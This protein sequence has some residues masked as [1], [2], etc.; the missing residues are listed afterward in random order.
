MRE[1]PQTARLRLPQ[2][3]NAVSLFSWC[4]YFRRSITGHATSFIA[5][6]LF[7]Q[8][9]LRR[10]WI[11]GAVIGVLG[12]TGDGS[13][14]DRLQTFHLSACLAVGSADIVCRRRSRREHDTVVINRTGAWNLRLPNRMPR[15]AEI[16]AEPS[17]LLTD[18][19]AQK[20]ERNRVHINMARIVWTWIT[21]PSVKRSKGDDPLSFAKFSSSVARWSGLKTRG[22]RCSPLRIWPRSAAMLDTL[23]AA[24]PDCARQISPSACST[25]S[26][27]AGRRQPFEMIGSVPR[28]WHCPN[29]RLSR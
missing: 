9:S 25:P 23:H 20:Y 24:C 3:L 18:S 11:P 1:Q 27:N 8:G 26:A 6:E 29:Q 15:L 4:P 19:D 12:A 21:S 22:A 13:L 7:G 5:P 28:M 2:S 10:S 14:T 17:N 16:V